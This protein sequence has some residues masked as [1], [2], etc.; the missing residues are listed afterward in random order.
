MHGTQDIANSRS[1]MEAEEYQ[2]KKSMAVAFH[3]IDQ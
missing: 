1:T 3:E 2:A